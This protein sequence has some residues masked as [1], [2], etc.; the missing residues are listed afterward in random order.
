MEEEFLL[1]RI[2]LLKC[3]TPKFF[4]VL[5]VK[6]MWL[7]ILYLKGFSQRRWITVLQKLIP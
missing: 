6:K 7:N 3:T 4:A 1:E 5:S 2:K